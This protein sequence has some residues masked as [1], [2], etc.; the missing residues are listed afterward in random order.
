MAQAAARC[1][2]RRA[3]PHRGR[4]RGRRRGERVCSSL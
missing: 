2:R 4:G 1:D 3:G